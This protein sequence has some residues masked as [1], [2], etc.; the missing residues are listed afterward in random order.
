MTHTLASITHAPD[1]RGKYVLMRVAFDVPLTRGRV[2]HQFRIRKAL[3]TIQYL[4][5][6][7]ARVI[8]LT[9]VGREG[10]EVTEPIFHA[11]K[12]YIPLTHIEAVVGEA[13]TKRIKVLTDGEVLLLGNVRAH[14]GEAANDPAFAKQLASYADLY[15]NDAF[16]VS[17]RAHASIVGISPYLPAYAGITF[18]DEY[19]HL[20]RALEPEHP[21]LFILGGAKFETKEPLVAA[22]SEHYTHTFIGGALANDFMR[23]RGCEVGQS[24][25]SDIDLLGK[26]LM[27][28]PHVMTP[29]DVVS[30]S[31]HHKR[32]ALCTDVRSD[33][34]ILDIGPETIETL[35]SYIKGAK[36]I[37]WNGPLGNYEAGYDTGTKACAEL[38]A[39]SGAFSIVGG[40]DTIAAIEALGLQDRFGFLS[41]AGGAMLEFLEKRTLPGIEALNNNPLS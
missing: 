25:L 3:P 39:Q 17:H 22:Y 10:T 33:E 9:H 32:V 11:L 38:I 24:L 21:S 23:A 19:M 5:A 7:G 30:V 36:T 16:A 12:A 29:S 6:E 2:I 31:E 4:M 34:K 1:L 18:M 13:V 28:N 35:A 8:L 40:G 15:V 37:L 14:E 41:T 27:Y 20:S 26:P